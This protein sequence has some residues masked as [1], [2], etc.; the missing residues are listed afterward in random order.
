MDTAIQHLPRKQTCQIIEKKYAERQ[1]S[2][3]ALP[4]EHGCTQTDLYGERIFN[5]LVSGGGFSVWVRIF[6]LARP[7]FPLL[8]LGC[9]GSRRPKFDY[10]ESYF[11]L[12]K[13]DQWQKLNKKSS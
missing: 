13:N 3:F 8:T 12:Y 11:S 1:K 10:E 4:V 6:D 7:R 5:E 2:T 9:H